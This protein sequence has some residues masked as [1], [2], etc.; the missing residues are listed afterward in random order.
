MSGF[1]AI[2]NLDGAPV[3]RGLLC[4]MAALLAF[5]GPDTQRV[6]VANHAGLGHALLRIPNESERDE[7]P[8]T[9][10]GRRWMV[11]D[12][13]VDGREDLIAALSARDQEA[14]A[15]DVPDVELLFRAYHAWGEEC[16]GH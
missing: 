11:A 8:F 15:T 12:A 9:L 5:R 1:V 4:R 7:Q 6:H 13:R 10:D 2:V 3:D 16:V 14:C